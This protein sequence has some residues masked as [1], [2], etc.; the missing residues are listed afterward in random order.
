LLSLVLF[1]LVLLANRCRVTGLPVQTQDKSVD[2]QM[3]LY[4][5]GSCNRPIR[6]TNPTSGSRVRL[7]LHSINGILPSTC[8]PGHRDPTHADP[9]HARALLPWCEK[10]GGLDCDHGHP[11]EKHQAKIR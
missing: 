8:H 7:A 9:S 1:A 11:D 5:F 10:G 2:R 6:T 3:P 4:R